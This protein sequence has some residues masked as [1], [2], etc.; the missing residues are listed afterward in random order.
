MISLELLLE[1]MQWA[2]KD[3]YTEI[4]KLDEGVLDH[5]IVDPEWSVKI[6]MLHIAKASNTY[7]QRLE[8]LLIKPLELEEPQTMKEVAELADILYSIDEGLI[9]HAKAE[10]INI[11]YETQDGEKTNKASTIVSQIVFHA[12]EHRAQIVAA[13]DKHKVLS[14]NL[15][16]YDIWSF[17]SL[18]GIL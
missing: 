2:N 6:I 10:D 4:S 13:L 18:R 15:D 12:T 3:I 11:T 16:N 17:V 8:G 7:G 14:I 5:Y 9:K 1:H